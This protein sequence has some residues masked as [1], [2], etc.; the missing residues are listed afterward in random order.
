MWDL[1]GLQIT[2]LHWSSRLLNTTYIFAGITEKIRKCLLQNTV[3][4]KEKGNCNARVMERY[5]WIYIKCPM[6]KKQNRGK[7]SHIELLC[8]EMCSIRENENCNYWNTK[9]EDIP[10]VFQ[11]ESSY[12]RHELVLDHYHQASSNLE[13][14]IDGLLNYINNI[15]YMTKWINY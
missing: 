6:E 2:E 12:I 11:V 7:S 15:N 14:P 4:G 3:E 5:C 9:R 8:S 1:Q 10:N 13:K